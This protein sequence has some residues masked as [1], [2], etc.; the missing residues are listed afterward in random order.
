M[1]VGVS[2]SVRVGRISAGPNIESRPSIGLIAIIMLISVIRQIETGENM[3]AE[4]ET[5]TRHETCCRLDD[6][7]TST[8]LAQR[9]A[10]HFPTE[11]R[12]YANA[13]IICLS[14]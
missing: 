13:L 12:Q 5:V 9:V 7:S 1:F 6:P 3:A 14:G 10:C 2:V 8:F 4:C 11:R